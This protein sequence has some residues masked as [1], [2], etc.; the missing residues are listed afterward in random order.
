MMKSS[1][2]LFILNDAYKTLSFLNIRDIIEITC[3][4]IQQLSCTNTRVLSIVA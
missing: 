1:V 3:R 2:L 4:N